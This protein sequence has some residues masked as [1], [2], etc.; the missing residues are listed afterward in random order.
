M[1]RVTRLLATRSS[2]SKPQRKSDEDRR[3]PPTP[4]VEREEAAGGAGAQYSQSDDTPIV[5][6]CSIEPCHREPNEDK[7]LCSNDRCKGKDGK[8][9]DVHLSC[10]QAQ[11]LVKEYGKKTNGTQRGKGSSMPFVDSIPMCP[12]C[13]KASVREWVQETD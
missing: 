6:L 3:T 10:F 5:E 2:P 8:P 12:R 9:R 11:T 7:V 13:T 4:P 1:L